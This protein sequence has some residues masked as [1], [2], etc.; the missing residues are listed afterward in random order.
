MVIIFGVFPALITA[1]FFTLGLLCAPYILY[2][3]YQNRQSENYQ[4]NMT[5]N[6]INSLFRVKFDSNVFK[7]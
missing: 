4:L 2:V 1:F 7:T 6:M 3:L 5:K